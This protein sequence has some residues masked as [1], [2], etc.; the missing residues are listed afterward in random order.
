[1]EFKEF[2]DGEIVKYDLTADIGILIRS[3]DTGKMHFLKA[4]SGK[5]STYLLPEATQE[6]VSGTSLEEKLMFLKIEMPTR[7]KIIETYI[8]NSGE[9]V[10]FK[11]LSRATLS[12]TE[13]R[14][15]RTYL[16]FKDTGKGYESLD[17][18]LIGLLEYKYQGTNSQAGEMFERMLQ[19]EKKET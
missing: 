3:R 16:N 7:D 12:T 8:L 19:M 2:K 18:A 1:M 15:Y 9:Y 14:L 6:N 13:V 10:I 11:V 17:G 4:G 5:Y